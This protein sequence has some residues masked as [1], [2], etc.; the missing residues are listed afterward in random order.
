MPDEVFHGA[1]HELLMVQRK[2]Q[3]HDITQLCLGPGV[4]APKM[5]AQTAE[6]PLELLVPCKQ[7]NAE[8][9]VDGLP[10][11]RRPRRGRER[12]PALFALTPAWDVE[13]HVV[14]VVV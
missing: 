2:R 12:G 3:L 1:L 14:V 7:Q 10:R 13:N 6:F 5:E 4:R 9:A 11:H 8:R